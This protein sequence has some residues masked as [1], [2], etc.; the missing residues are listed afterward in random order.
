MKAARGS[1]GRSLDRPDPATRLYLLYGPDDGQSRAL[2]DR[3]LKGLGASRF[4]VANTAAVRS[5]P[6]LLAD[7][8]GAMS[9]FGE[10]RAIWVEGGD[11]LAEA[12]EALLAAPAS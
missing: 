1:I 4:V 2:G 7:E 5:D 9:L 10:A 3:L 6:A 8:A 11:E 12:A